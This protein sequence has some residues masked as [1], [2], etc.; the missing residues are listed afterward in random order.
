[1]STTK[2]ASKSRS[3]R[4]IWAATRASRVGAP[5]APELDQPVHGHLHGTVD[6]HHHVQAHGVAVGRLEEGDGEDEDALPGIG[7]LPPGEHGLPDGRVCDGVEIGERCGIREDHG[8]HRWTIEGAVRSEDA[9]AEAL[10]EGPVGG[11]ARLHHLPGDL[12]G[13]DELGA[14]RHQQLGD[15]G[16]P[17]TDAP[18]QADR[19]HQP[20][21][22]EG[23]WP[24]R[25]GRRAMAKS[26]SVVSSVVSVTN[27][28]SSVIP[29]APPV[30][31]R[32]MTR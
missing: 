8:G 12:V 5:H 4:E 30:S 29:V 20:D 3:S 10:D 13:V 18:G 1:M 28:S 17:R 19:E 2:S 24:G 22:P 32:A 26:T 9:V 16:L 25:R 6:H 14:T 31:R 23:G 21:E 11:L 7:G 15:R 27:Q